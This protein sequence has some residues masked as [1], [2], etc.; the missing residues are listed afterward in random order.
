MAD[1]INLNEL[2][3]NQE[4]I[5]EIAKDQIKGRVVETIK[6][7]LGVSTVNEANN[8]LR[9][10]RSDIQSTDPRLRS[11]AEKQITDL[12]GVLTMKVFSQDLFTNELLA[13]E[14]LVK[15]FDD[16]W[17]EFGN[18]K[19]YILEPETGFSNYDA[20]KFVEDE[21]TDL[22]TEATTISLYQT[23]GKTLTTNARQWKKK[24]VCVE[25]RLIQFFLSGKLT[26]FIANRL[27]K[28][29][30][31][32]LVGQYN[33]IMKFICQKTGGKVINDTTSKNVIEAWEN[34][35]NVIN[36]MCMVSSKYAYNQTSKIPRSSSVDDILMFANI[37][38][39]QKLKTTK[40]FMYGPDYFNSVKKL[41]DSNLIVVGYEYDVKGDGEIIGTKENYYLDNDTI[42]LLDRNESIKILTAYDEYARQDYAPNMAVG[43]YKHLWWVFGM[44]S[45]GKKA[46]ITCNKFLT[47]AEPA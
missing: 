10:M 25:R 1:K 45:W 16:G 41:A 33:E 27:A 9:Q 34:V 21:L 40:A 26:E 42:I 43:H 30:H 18:T 36:D 11:I 31:G 8:Q 23:D 28:L 14:N 24:F 12:A 37:N 29:A 22:P 4:V 38:V 20:T 3:R 2:T 15:M 35:F 47:D 5:K 7:E 39:Y 6:E 19:E 32:L 46:V 44:L 13:D 17:V